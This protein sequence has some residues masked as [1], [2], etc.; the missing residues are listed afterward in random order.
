ML[1]TKEQKELFNKIMK[2]ID[3]NNK[4]SIQNNN[5]TADTNSHKMNNQ[6]KY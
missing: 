5:E 6:L 1:N 4:K 2:Q 3:K